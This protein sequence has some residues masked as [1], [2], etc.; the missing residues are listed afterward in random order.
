MKKLL[1]LLL[2]V[3]MTVG[4]LSACGPKNDVTDPT[5]DI[6][7]TPDGVATD[8][9]NV[10]D[11][12]TDPA[13]AGGLR[14]AI[15]TSPSGVDDGSF[16]QNNYEGILS[17]INTHP[18]SSVQAIRETDINNSVP[19]VEAIVADYDVVV[20]PGFQ[21]ATVSTIAL[22]NP[23]KYFVIV[24]EFPAAI[25]GQEIFDNVLGLK[26]AEEEG[27]FFAGVAAAMQTTTGKV[28]VVNGIAY[29]SNV[30]YQYGFESGVAY[31]NKHLGTSAEVVSL[32]SYAGTDVTGA[33]VGGNYI[34][35]FDDEAG[36][37]VVG[38]ALLKEGVDIIFVAAG[39]AGNGVFT[40]V[41]E[42]GASFV[43]GC[44]VDQYDDG[45]NGASNI[46]LTSV[47]KVMDINVDR[48]L[49]AI[50]SGT[51]VGANMTLG[52]SSDSTGFIKA[53]G[54]HQMSDET[55][56]ALDRVYGLVKDNTIIPAANFNGHTPTAFP[57]L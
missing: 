53:P 34:G 8:D 21:F 47:L 12:N 43:I 11:D 27:G 22:D 28:A 2:V 1:A 32:P 9:P 52:A 19:T 14:V 50:A 15:V 24:D 16:N 40:A 42:H 51:F 31:A 35:S 57:G 29:P 6:Q 7:N 26:F 17:F 55:V 3:A 25:D 36:G 18:G 46:I 41:K 48:A 30:N 39:G 4:M 23:D 49:T 56:T 54:R 13:P 44:D 38:E 5:P 20:A 37:K 33:N 45:A 10:T